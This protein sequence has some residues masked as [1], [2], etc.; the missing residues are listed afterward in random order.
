MMFAVKRIK[1]IYN[2]ASKKVQHNISNETII[3]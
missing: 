1:Q 2:A 3:R